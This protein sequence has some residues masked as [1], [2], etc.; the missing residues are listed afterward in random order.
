MDT[1]RRLVDKTVKNPDNFSKVP[2]HLFDNQVELS[3]LF[4]D[5]L[6]AN[7]AFCELEAGDMLYLPASWFHEVTSF[8]IGCNKYTCASTEQKE[9]NNESNASLGHL[10]FNYWFHPPDNLENFE[11]PYSTN[12][13]PNDFNLRFQK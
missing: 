10:A 13:W 9:T 1:N 6:K 3:Q 5:F 2:V 11:N 8:G 4:P 7:A 12:F